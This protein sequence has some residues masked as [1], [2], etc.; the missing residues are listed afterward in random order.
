MKGTLVSAIHKKNKIRFTQTIRGYLE[1][2]ECRDW[3]GLGKTLLFFHFVY[4]SG[5]ESVGKLD[6]TG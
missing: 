4:I 5:P 1:V 6:G 2:E 3:V